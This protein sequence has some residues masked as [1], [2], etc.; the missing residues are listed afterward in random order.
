MTTNKYRAHQNLLNLKS[1]VSGKIPNIPPSTRIKDVLFTA[2]SIAPGT[3][4]ATAVADIKCVNPF[5]KIN[6][7]K[8]P[9]LHTPLIQ[10]S[11][12]NKKFSMFKLGIICLLF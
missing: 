8:S 4:V 2:Y 1:S 6:W 11:I 12:F 3:H 5:I 9:L 7:L 10:Y